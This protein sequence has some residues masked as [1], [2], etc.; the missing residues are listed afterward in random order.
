MFLLR[1]CYR[2]KQGKKTL[3]ERGGETIENT[4]SKLEQLKEEDYPYFS[5]KGQTFYAKHCHIYDGDTF[6]VMFIYKNEVIKYRCRMMGYDS[7][8][9]KPLLKNEDRVHEKELAILAKNRLKELLSVH[10][11]QLI[12]IECFDFDKYGRLLVNV[13]NMVDEK[14]I[15]NIMIEEKHGKPYFGGKKEEWT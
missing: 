9:M 6:S 10:P 8:E 13:W 5:F 7:P 14:S 11:T 4:F 2:K 1:C 15:N 12:K 3:Y